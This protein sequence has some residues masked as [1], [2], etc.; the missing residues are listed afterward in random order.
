MED[1]SQD[2]EGEGEDEYVDS[3]REREREERREGGWGGVRMG[4]WV[5]ECHLQRN[6]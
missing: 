4:E 3:E 1:A 6:V 2:E 5:S